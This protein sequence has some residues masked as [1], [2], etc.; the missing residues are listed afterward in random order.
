MITKQSYSRTPRLYGLIMHPC[1]SWRRMC[2]ALGG[3]GGLPLLGVNATLA[4][5]CP[6]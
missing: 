3:V 5:G 6:K 1:G 2:P 4:G